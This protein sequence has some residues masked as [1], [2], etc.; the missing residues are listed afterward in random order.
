MQ[1]EVLSVV[2]KNKGENKMLRD[3]II[4][5]IES[6]NK[7]QV[8]IELRRNDILNYDS[9]LDWWQHKYTAECG[10]I[11]ITDSNM[12]FAICKLALKLQ[13]DRVGYYRELEERG[14]RK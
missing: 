8:F 10:D 13:E 11:T 4:F 9:I 2:D 3:K 12:L 14:F 1:V 7:S 5:R 6:K